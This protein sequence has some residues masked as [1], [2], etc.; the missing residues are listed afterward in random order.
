MGLEF[1]SVLVWACVSHRA[2]P[3]ATFPLSVAVA[4]DP[5]GSPVTDATWLDQEL[6][7][8]NALFA[9]FGVGFTRSESKPLDGRFAH[10]ETRDDRDALAALLQSKVVN[11][12]VVGSLRDVDDPSRMRHGV[13]WHAPSGAHYVVVVA[14]SHE[15][16]LGHELG[17]FFGNP[18]SKVV[19]NVMSYERSGAAVFFDAEQGR[20]IKSRE[21]AYVG[22]G[23]LVP[24]VA[25][26]QPTPGSSR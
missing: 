10:L 3:I 13:H 17:H 19:D 16:V 2:P 8:A 18:H 14:G 26:A 25:P 22:A 12:F 4:E 20:R 11:V 23:E 9:P 7:T 1:L 15:S 5:A 24:S 6:D 21:L